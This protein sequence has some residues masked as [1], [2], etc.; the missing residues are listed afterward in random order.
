MDMGMGDG[1]EGE[2]KRQLYFSFVI[3][4]CYVCKTVLDTNF[5]LL[6]SQ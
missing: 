2:E 1:W 5:V 4:N 3:Q 6:C